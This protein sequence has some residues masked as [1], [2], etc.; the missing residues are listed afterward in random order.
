MSGLSP[1]RKRT[2]LWLLGLLA[3]VCLGGS[4]L[5]ATEGPVPKGAHKSPP[6]KEGRREIRSENSRAVNK[7]PE[8]HHG[9][10]H[11]APRRV[12]ARTSSAGKTSNHHFAQASGHRQ[13]SNS[14]YHRVRTL[15]GQ[16][17]LA[18]L[19]LE[20]E[21]VDEI[22]RALIREGFLQG[23][24]TGQWDA[25]TRDAMLRF[26]TMHGFPATGLPEAKSL[27]KLGLGSHPLPPDLDH[28]LVGIATPGAPQGDLSVPPSA[29][30]SSQ[31]VPPS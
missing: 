30:T 22:Q 1:T 9:A 15:S 3:G 10:A 12:G 13:Y 16:Q 27:M 4:G 8:V 24:P 5:C 6:Q 17:R 21:R 26:Q 28:G 14:R 23:D 20:P 25:H 19:H 29:P 31:S 18:R 2:S 11:Y 7:R